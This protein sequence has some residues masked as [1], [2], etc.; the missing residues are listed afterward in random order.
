VKKFV[1]K[2]DLALLGADTIYPDGR[3]LNKIG[4]ATIAKLCH[5]KSKEVTVA[6]SSS[7]I[8]LKSMR[9]NV[10]NDIPKI[11]IPDRNPKEI[12]TH[13][14][15]K[16]TIWNKY[17]ELVNPKFISTLI[18]NENCFSSPITNGLKEFI[19]RKNLALLAN[20]LRDL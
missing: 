5:F 17:F 3:I 10:N 8:S 15:R 19:K 1:D 16:V 2:S 6:A 12:S 11:I 14:D 7:K 4:S 20:P 18:M 9:D 13:S